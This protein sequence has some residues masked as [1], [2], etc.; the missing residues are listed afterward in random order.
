MMFDKNGVKD[1]NAPPP[2]PDAGDKQPIA[3]WTAEYNL[4]TGAFRIVSIPNDPFV[5]LGMLKLMEVHALG[6]MKAQP[7]RLV[8]P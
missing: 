4:A 7:S 5:S 6:T 2:P 3:R 1:K 8:K